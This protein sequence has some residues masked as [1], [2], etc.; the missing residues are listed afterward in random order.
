MILKETSKWSARYVS[1]KHDIRF[2][3]FGKDAAKAKSSTSRK[4]HPDKN[5]AAKILKTKA[6]CLYVSWGLGGGVSWGLGGGLRTQG[7]RSCKKSCLKDPRIL[8]STTMKATGLLHTS[9]T[10]DSLRCRS[11]P[12]Q[13]RILALKTTVMIRVVGIGCRV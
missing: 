2:I 1:A 11:I 13:S 5:P 4:F 12:G 9:R 6:R 7:P 10:L 3:L 8:G